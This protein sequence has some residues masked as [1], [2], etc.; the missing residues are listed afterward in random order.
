MTKHTEVRGSD[1]L[2]HSPITAGLLRDK[3]AAAIA[4][5]IF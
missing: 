1:G 5:S 2:D 3:Q 4:R